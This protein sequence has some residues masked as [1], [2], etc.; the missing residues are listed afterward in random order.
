MIAILLVFAAG[1]PFGCS[2]KSSPGGHGVPYTEERAPCSK[3][4]PLK[5]LYFG[6]LHSHTSS[7]YDAWIWG[8]RATPEDAYRFARGERIGLEP[9]NPE[10]EPTRRLKLE[11]PLDFA[12]V[13]DHSEFFGE[14]D[15]CTAPGLSVYDSPSCSLIRDGN[16]MSM[17]IFSN[18]IFSAS[19]ARFPD[20]CGP[21]GIDCAERARVVWQRTQAAAEGAYDRSADCSFT[22]FVAYEYTDTAGISNLHRNVIFRNAA[23]PDLPVSYLEQATPLG[24]LSELE[25]ICPGSG[26]G[27]EAISIPHNS[28]LSNGR[29]FA[30]EYPGAQNREEEK[31]LAALR[32]RREPLAE[33]FQHKGDSECRQSFSGIQGPDDDLCGFEKSNWFSP[34][35]CGAGTGSGGMMGQGCLSRWDFIR[36]ALLKGLLE[37]E[38]L[39]VNP[40]KLGII[41][42]TDT[43]NATPGAVEENRY[44]GHAGW[45]EDSISKRLTLITY[46]PLMIAA[47]PG[48]LTA[49]WAEENSRDSIFNALLR[50]ETYATSGPRI[51]VRFFGGWNLPGSMCGASSLV[52]IG[53]REGVPMGG[54]LPPMPAGVSA[55]TFGILAARD[56]GGGGRTG[57]PL[58]RV[59]VI[60]GWLETATQPAYRVYEVA[61]DPDNGASVDPT[62]CEI[63]GAGFDTLCTVWTDPDFHPGQRAFYYARVIENPTCRWSTIQCHLLAP[64]LR[65]G[66]CDDPLIPKVIQERAWTSP[67]WYR[68]EANS[69]P[70]G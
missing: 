47:N 19:P 22:S 45:N 41:A 57:T 10:G 31:A 8:S 7:S 66:P 67:V 21:A 43:H 33:I 1:G 12:A 42:S 69:N 26:E 56:P 62:T 2:H 17:L 58:Q 37:E 55:P 18:V 23:V 5:N 39:G 63:A 15:A 28:N 36:P 9:F 13:T 16:D 48:G 68:P 25:R 30:A 49:V 53:S 6:D 52:E 38:R 54:D 27:C 64:D 40:F 20:I 32:A 51:S 35:D 61:G 3:S 29:M 50:R 34:E 24:F 59:Q 14:T 60:K 65:P 44:E 11:R 70:P 4:N 46:G